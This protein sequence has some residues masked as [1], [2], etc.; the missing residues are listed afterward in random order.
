[1]SPGNG[2]QK[3]RPMKAPLPGVPT[4]VLAAG[5]IS[6]LLGATAVMYFLLWITGSLV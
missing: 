6:V 1:M 3:L 4:H 5:I 2:P